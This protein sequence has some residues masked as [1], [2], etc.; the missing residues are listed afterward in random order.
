MEAL[1]TVKKR[2]NERRSTFLFEDALAVMENNISMRDR[3]T[4]LESNE[5]TDDTNQTALITLSGVAAGE[6]DLGTF[7]GSIIADDSTI[8]AAL[9]ALETDLEA[10]QTAVGIAAEATSLG[11]FTGT[12]ITDNRTVKQALQDVETARENDT[13]TTS[14]TS[15]DTNNTDASAISIVTLV[16]NLVSGAGAETRTLAAPGASIVKRKIVTMTT[17]GGGDITL[18]MTNIVGNLKGANTNIVF[19]DAGD[20]IILEANGNNTWLLIAY[21]GVTLS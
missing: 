12:T 21:H 14:A 11:T 9:Q 17:D 13:I 8:K 4:V 19:N 1:E 7:T 5:S 6:A 10:L 15:T 18:A 16:T 2:I 3:I 20:S